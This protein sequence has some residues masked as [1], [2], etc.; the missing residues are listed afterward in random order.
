MVVGNRCLPNAAFKLKNNV[1]KS[2]NQTMHVGGIV[3]D[4]ANAFFE[5]INH[6]I[7]LVKLQFYGNHWVWANQFRS[8]LTNRKQKA[9]IKLSNA[10]QNCFFY[11]GILKH[12]ATQG[13]IPGLLTF[14]IYIYAFPTKEPIIFAYDTNVINFS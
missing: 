5:C 14:I 6:A 7:V 13:S 3:C 4:Q 11:L 8:H 1:F 2:T 12:G 10:T 9:E